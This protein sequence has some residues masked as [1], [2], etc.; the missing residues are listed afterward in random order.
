M[1]K[2]SNGWA[3][4]RRWRLCV[5]LTGADGSVGWLALSVAIAIALIAH[6]WVVTMKDGP[7]AAAMLGAALLHGGTLPETVAQARVIG[8]R[9]GDERSS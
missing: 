6:A 9:Y 4:A 5:N 1:R 7:I 2:A 3:I 8:M